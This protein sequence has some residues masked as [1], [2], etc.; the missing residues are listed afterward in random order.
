MVLHAHVRQH[1]RTSMCIRTSACM[2]IRIRVWTCDT[3]TYTCEHRSSC[4]PASSHLRP[5]VFIHLGVCICVLEHGG[6]DRDSSCC[7]VFSGAT[8]LLSM[9]GRACAS[10]S[11]VSVGVQLIGRAADV[12]SSNAP[13]APWRQILVVGVAALVA[14]MCGVTQSSP[15]VLWYRV[16]TSVKAPVSARMRAHWVRRGG[17]LWG[18]SS[19]GRQGG[20]T[21]W[22]SPAFWQ[23]LAFG[24]CVAAEP[25]R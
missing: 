16:S 4:M 11:C 25:K 18:S 8:L 23:E 21:Q 13:P 1:L 17:K 2:F 3:H 9:P 24:S 22:M 10:R 15:G 14:A 12:A 5:R 19:D 6:A 7:S 20:L